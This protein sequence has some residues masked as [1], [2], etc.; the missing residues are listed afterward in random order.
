MQLDFSTNNCYFPMSYTS[1]SVSLFMIF[2]TLG[3]IDVIRIV[4][5][6]QPFLTQNCNFNTWNV[7]SNNIQVMKRIYNS[8]LGL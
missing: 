2:Q 8:C 5:K 3:Y 7:E 4:P 1:I 6:T